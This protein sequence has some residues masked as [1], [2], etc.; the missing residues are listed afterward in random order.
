MTLTIDDLARIFAGWR[1]AEFTGWATDPSEQHI[2]IVL[3]KE[4]RR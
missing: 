1:I 4:A 2:T 3:R